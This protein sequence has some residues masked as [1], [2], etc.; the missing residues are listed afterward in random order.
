MAFKVKEIWNP[1]WPFFLVTAFPYFQGL[2]LI[3]DWEVK[4]SAIILCLRKELWILFLLYCRRLGRECKSAKVLSEASFIN[5]NG[6]RHLYATNKSIRGGKELEMAFTAVINFRDC[7]GWW[8]LNPAPSCHPP[9]AK[10]RKIKQGNSL[11]ILNT[12]SARLQCLL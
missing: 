10:Q 7:S 4:A 6:N 3:K 2:I 1:L 5:R 9:G 12:R 8:L 11:V